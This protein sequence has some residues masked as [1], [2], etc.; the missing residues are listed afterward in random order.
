MLDPYLTLPARDQTGAWFYLSTVLDD[1]SRYIL[2][3]KLCTA[4]TAIDVTE[5]LPLALNA[6]GLHQAI[7]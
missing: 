6:A 5:T 2:G 3:W 1:F 7:V 4:M